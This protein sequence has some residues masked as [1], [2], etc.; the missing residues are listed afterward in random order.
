M[1]ELRARHRNR[2]R[3]PDAPPV[4]R[5]RRR[6]GVRSLHA[7]RAAGADGTLVEATAEAAEAAITAEPVDGWSL[8]DQ[9]DAIAN[10]AVAPPDDDSADDDGPD[11]DDGEFDASKLQIEEVPGGFVIGPFPY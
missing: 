5:H 7:D 8:S 9:L 4:P 6:D 1:S 11:D 10:D 2:P 3:V